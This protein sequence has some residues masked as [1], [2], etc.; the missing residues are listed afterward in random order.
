MAGKI[1]MNASHEE[2]AMALRKNRIPECW[3]KLAPNTTMHL[4]TWL[5]HLQERA[6]QYKLWSDSGE[7][8]VMWLSGLHAPVSYLKAIVQ[9]DCR[10]NIWPI[11][12]TTLFTHVTEYWNTNQVEDRPEM[13]K[14]KRI[15]T[16]CE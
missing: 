12:C 1:S 4:S 7:P 3:Q 5:C 6:Q 10:K 14:S 8:T 15:L 13:V 11:E 2:I 16:S 9:T